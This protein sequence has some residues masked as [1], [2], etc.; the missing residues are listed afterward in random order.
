MPSTELAWY[1]LL[2]QEDL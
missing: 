1:A 2:S